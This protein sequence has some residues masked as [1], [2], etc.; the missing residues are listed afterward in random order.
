[1]EGSEPRTRAS[2]IWLAHQPQSLLKPATP[3]LKEKA[4]LRRHHLPDA[5]VHVAHGP[6][7]N[8]A[9]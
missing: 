4:A 7:D 8:R 5:V 2:T 1:M 9:R 3:S 6:F